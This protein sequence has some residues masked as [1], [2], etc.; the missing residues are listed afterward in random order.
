MRHRD[1]HV[2][3]HA[4]GLQG[5]GEMFKRLSGQKYGFV[6]S[7]KVNRICRELVY[8][9]VGSPVF[10]NPV[11]SSSIDTEYIQYTCYGCKQG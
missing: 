2:C 7:Q 3:S 1:A 4:V 6:F 9:L 5:P 11:P 8:F 10:F